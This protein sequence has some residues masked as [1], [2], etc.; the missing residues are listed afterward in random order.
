MKVR[1]QTE[2][3]GT[4]ILLFVLS[5][6]FL[7]LSGA[8]CVSA[9]LSGSELISD[10]TLRAGLSVYFEKSARSIT[11]EDLGQIYAVKLTDTT[12]SIGGVEIVTGLKK[13]HAL[14][15][16][17][18]ESI[19]NLD[20][21]YHSVMLSTPLSD[22]SWLERLPNLQYLALEGS[23]LK[24]GI[25]VGAFENLYA[26][27]ITGDSK[28]GF[29]LASLSGLENLRVLTVTDSA[30]SDLSALSEHTELIR[31]NLSQNEIADLSPLTVLTQLRVLALEKN[32]VEDV[33]ALSDLVKLEYLDLADNRVTDLSALGQ[34]CELRQLTLSNEKEGEGNSVSDL[35]VVEGFENLEFLYADRNPVGSLAPLSALRRL[36]AVSLNECGLSGVESLGTPK[37]LSYLSLK[38]NDLSDVSS[39]AD[40][41]KLS[42]L[43]LDGN[44]RLS[45]TDELKELAERV[46]I[47][48]V[49]SAEGEE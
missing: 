10:A 42:Y 49:A 9:Y 31:L 5:A 43:F 36:A 17:D 30:L 34:L 11:E 18:T 45:V 48:V 12:I 33:S 29:D 47:D 24:G 16:T 44:K 46:Q 22:Y 40:L 19:L 26:L 39:L 8:I 2:K 7:F 41:E 1:H 27:E 21:Y 35:S 25:R 38:G 23:A 6:L 14:S 13:N 4:T 28:T 20:S 37:K 32:A 3:R 15:V